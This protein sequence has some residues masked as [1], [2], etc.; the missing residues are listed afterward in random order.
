MKV[1]KNMLIATLIAL[2]GVCFVG[3]GEVDTV[4]ISAK[5]GA[6][7]ARGEDGQSC[8]VLDDVLTCGNTTFDLGNLE[9]AA[10][11]DGVLLVIDP[12]DPGGEILIVLNDGRVIAW[13]LDEG[14]YVLS[15]GLNYRTTDNEQCRFDLDNGVYSDESGQVV[16]L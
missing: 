15:E 10:G 12:C 9:G 13:Y 1:I 11:T 3:C 4:V 16:A 2:T 5:N 6:D 8:E 7:G 14:L